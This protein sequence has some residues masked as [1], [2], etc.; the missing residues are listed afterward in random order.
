MPG[1]RFTYRITGK[2]PWTGRPARILRQLDPATHPDTFE[3]EIPGG[4]HSFISGLNLRSIPNKTPRKK[5]VARA[6]RR[7]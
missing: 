5:K 1:K 3:I 6:S 7:K 2:G 4:M